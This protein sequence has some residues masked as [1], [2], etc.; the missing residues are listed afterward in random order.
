MLQIKKMTH[1][2]VTENQTPKHQYPVILCCVDWS[3]LGLDWQ[4]GATC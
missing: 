1:S 4:Q 3:S 2:L